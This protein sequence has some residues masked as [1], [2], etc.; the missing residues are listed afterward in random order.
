[1]EPKGPQL[2]LLEVARQ[3]GVS[4]TTVSRALGS[5]PV[6]P[7]V[8]QRVLQAAEAL[9]YRKNLLAQKLRSNRSHFVGLLIPDV[10]NP[11]F[12]TLA[13]AVERVF[14]QHGY[15]V[16]LCNSEEDP[17]TE[18]FYIHTLLDNQVDA[19]VLTPVTGQLNP[20]LLAAGIPVVLADRVIEAPPG[21]RLASVTCDNHRGGQLAARALLDRGAR[22]IVVLSPRHPGFSSSLAARLAGFVEEL[23]L[24]GV[25]S[26][27]QALEPEVAAVRAYLDSL[28][29]GSFDAL[30]CTSDLVAFPTIKALQDLGLAVPNDVQVVGFDGLA[31]GEVLE[32]STIRQDL[33]RVGQAVG[34]AA[35]ALIAGK[36]Y[37]RDSVVPVELVARRSLRQLPSEF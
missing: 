9:G 25:T 36:A 20:R 10:S 22:R 28:P 27:Q 16:F 13:Q 33:D 14:R 7:E 3:A 23:A 31:L 2:R 17:A 12:A 35:L 8:R 11:F 6:S 21:L 4:R 37:P 29:R 34:E 15:G 30:F 18:D 32:L 26:R 24:A 5:G 1:M 19:L